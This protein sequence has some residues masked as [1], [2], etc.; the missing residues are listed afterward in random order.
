MLLISFSDDI[1]RDSV[2]DFPVSSGSTSF[3]LTLPSTAAVTLDVVRG[4]GVEGD[5]GDGFELF[6][7]LYA[8]GD[9]RDIG[10]AFALAPTVMLVVTLGVETEEES[11]LLVGW[12]LCGR[13]CCSGLGMAADIDV[14]VND[15]AKYFDA[16][17]G[18]CS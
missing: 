14:V 6:R 11:S 12:V 13:L 9:L 7:G 17:S 1:T 5:C 2:N 18:C 15:D 16:G 3:G 4:V 8:G 10:G